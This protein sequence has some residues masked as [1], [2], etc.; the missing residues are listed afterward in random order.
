[1]LPD[2]EDIETDLVRRLDLLKE[3]AKPEDGID[4]GPSDRI[5]RR[6]DETIDADLHFSF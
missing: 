3:I 6:G 2:A 5:S 1:M 4:F